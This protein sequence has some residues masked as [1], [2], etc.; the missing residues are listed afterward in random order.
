M[1]NILL[2]MC[3][4]ALSINYSFEMYQI[5]FKKNY[6]QS[7]LSYRNRIFDLQLHQIIMHNSNPTHT[8]KQGVNFFTD[9]TPDEL[10]QMRGSRPINNINK[11]SSPTR[12][13]YSILN[14][15]QDVDWR[16]RNVV[17]PVK[18][19][20][21]CGSCWAF[22]AAET[23]ESHRA[24]MNSK[25]EELSEQQI[26]DC[27][28][29]A[30]GCGGGTVGLAFDQIIRAGGI[31]AEWTYPYTS[32]DGENFECNKSKSKYVAKL[33]GYEILPKNEQDPI[34]QYLMNIGPLAISIDAS[35]WHS[36]ESGIFDGCNRTDIDIDHAVQLVGYG[37]DKNL[38]MYWL[39]R[40]SWG[41]DWGENG[42][43]RLRRESTVSC[44]TYISSKEKICGMC[45]ILYEAVYPNM[46]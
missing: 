38:G 44:G 16:L 28:L 3:I 8:W 18:N 22:A 42:Y 34:L 41:P 13:F 39:I 1:I 24:I 17:T 19:Q 21:R 12:R 29:E 40:N 5:E 4:G 45:G 33:N 26:L 37:T 30:D 32:F 10:N 36:Y 27:T 14:L 43:I 25:L 15:K 23:L 6:I 31:S 9:R 35:S 46:K 7:E 11:I 20:G 2:L